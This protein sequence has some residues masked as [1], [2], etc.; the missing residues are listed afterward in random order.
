M[1][2]SNT[3]T[4]SEGL[5]FVQSKKTRTLHSGIKTSPCEAVEDRTCGFSLECRH[6]LSIET[7]DELEQLFNARMKNGRDEE[8]TEEAN[9][10][11]RID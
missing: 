4:W 10:Q 5:R 9:Q 8:E 7:E 6:A 2:D 11:P 1:S 3:K